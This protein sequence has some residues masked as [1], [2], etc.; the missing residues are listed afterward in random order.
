MESIVP[1]GS[2]NQDGATVCPMHS[3]HPMAKAMRANRRILGEEPQPCECG[4]ER[5]GGSA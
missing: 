2:D 3:P 4:L 5:P 1:N